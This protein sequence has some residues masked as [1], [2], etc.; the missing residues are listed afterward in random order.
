V[1]DAAIKKLTRQHA[2]L[3][4]HHV[5]ERSRIARDLQHTFLK[6]GPVAVATGA[7]TDGRTRPKPI[8]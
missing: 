2:N 8:G 4:F 1:R 3:N 5:V 7:S 6:N